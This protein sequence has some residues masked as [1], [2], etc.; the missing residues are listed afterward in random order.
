MEFEV[1]KHGY[2]ECDK[3]FITFGR[4]MGKIVRIPVYCFLVRHPKGNVLIDT[5]FSSDFEK[6]WNNRLS[7]FKPSIE[8]D[9]GV[10][11]YG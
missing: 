8:K 2:L 11:V 9:V 7:F 10:L 3:G 6:T 4:D 5:G 1:I